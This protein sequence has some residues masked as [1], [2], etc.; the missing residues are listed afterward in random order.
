MAHHSPG[1]KVTVPKFHRGECPEVQTNSSKGILQTTAVL[2]MNH[3]NHFLTKIFAITN[4]SSTY[5]VSMRKSIGGWKSLVL[6][7]HLPILLINQKI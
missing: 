3:N 5:S 4:L 6:L 2:T 1:F 7:A